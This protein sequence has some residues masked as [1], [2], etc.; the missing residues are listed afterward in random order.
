[1][2][3]VWFI[4]VLLVTCSSVVIDASPASLSGLADY[5]KYIDPLVSEPSFGVHYYDD[6]AADATVLFPHT[7]SE[8]YG[9]PAMPVIDLI[10]L[11]RSA[12]PILI[13]CLSDGRLTSVVFDG[14]RITKR[15][16]VPV[17]YVCLDILMQTV[18]GTPV[19]ADCA[20]D[21][22]GACMNDGYY[23]R[24]DD[25]S[26]CLPKRG[27]CSLRPIIPIVQR[28]WR[29]EYRQRHLHFR[30]PYD[31]LAVDQYKDLIT[32]K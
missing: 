22:L 15:M 12:F 20:A 1:M 28:N 5:K 8:P 11:R 32:Q 10:R 7:D 14:N 31:L 3:S 13:D 23:F 4:G 2:R 16:N 29:R 17:G 25:Y 19:D 18:V 21:G 30:N 6:G 24:P 9:R 27:A 26:N